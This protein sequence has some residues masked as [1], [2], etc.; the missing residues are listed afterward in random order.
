MRRAG[1]PL[2]YSQGFSPHPKISIAAPLPIGVTSEGEL[3]DV[4][5]GKRVSPY[6]IIKVLADQLPRGVG[7]S[8][9]VQVP[10]QSPS[11]Q[12]QVKRAEYR[13][14]MHDDR[15]VEGIEKAIGSFLARTELPWQ[16]ERDKEVRNYDLRALVDRVWLIGKEGA[17]C[18]IGMCL[19]ADNRATGRAEQV[20]M[21]L[22]FNG[23]P[24]SIH[25]TKLLLA[26]D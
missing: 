17:L 4:S 15:G 3:M 22:G 25:R 18:T 7:I 9:V 21:A 16:H 26:G 1:I 8:S 14:E 2:A 6:F 11:L 19:R 10:M 24:R 5:L 23:R 20:A 12:S 13:V